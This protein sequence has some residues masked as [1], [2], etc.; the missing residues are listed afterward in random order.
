MLMKEIWEAF[1][2]ACGFWLGAGYGLWDGM[3]WE[4][5]DA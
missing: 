2:D 1:F 4:G 3:G 5:C